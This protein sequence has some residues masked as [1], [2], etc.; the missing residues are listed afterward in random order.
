MYQFSAPM[1]YTIEDIKKLLDINKHVEK[2][3]ITSLF[4]SLPS[5]NELFTGFEQKRNIFFHKTN[6]EYWKKL[7]IY[8][9]N[10]G[11]DIIYL[12]NS[13][14]GISIENPELEQQLEKL[15][16]LLNE[17]RKQGVNKLRIANHNLLS[18]LN[19]HYND[20]N[21]YASTSF[22]L[23]T[24]CEYKNFM[25]VH[26][27]VKQII[28]A[29]D[30]IRN[31]KLLKNI[32][33]SLFDTDIEL[34]VNEGCINGCPLRTNHAS[35]Y[36]DKNILYRNDN[37]LSSFYDSEFFC[38]RY[39]EKNL[40]HTLIKSNNIFP[41]D[42]ETYAKAGIKKF[43]LVGRDS[44]KK[45]IETY[46]KSYFYYLKGI[47]NIKEIENISVNTFIYHLSDN[48]ALKK[49]TVKDIY[50]YL[51]KIKHFDKYGEYCSYQCGIDCLYCYKCAEKIQK[52]YEKKM[53]KI[54]KSRIYIPAC[55]I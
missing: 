46:L 29:H 27:Y 22:E 35:N 54:A 51:P 34:M 49:L 16:K 31:I 1:P 18:Y 55:K 42:I 11:V 2:S 8:C 13:P 12:L 4:F 48:T 15:D 33:K 28:P 3:K 9:L 6:W 52:I 50:K 40:F 20:F 10:S 23:K 47:D 38:G 25:F 21:L 19:K 36:L 44:L 30:C 43:K 39:A 24:L 7:I 17:L 45:N 5:T 14:K 26:P 53:N 41:W 32:K 37:T